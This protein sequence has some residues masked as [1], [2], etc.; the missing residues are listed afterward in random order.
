[1]TAIQPSI[2][3]Y[4]DQSLYYTKKDVGPSVRSP[5]SQG[6]KGENQN[7]ETQEDLEASKANEE[8]REGPFS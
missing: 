1:V 2:Y 3:S 7:S 8:G 6:S 5:T 4:K